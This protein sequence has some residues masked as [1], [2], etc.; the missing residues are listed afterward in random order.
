MKII[1]LRKDL[2]YV[3]V[4]DHDLK[5]FDVAIIT[6]YGTSYNSYL[7]KTPEGVVVF[8]GSKEKTEAEYLANLSSLCDFSEIKYL[9]VTH[10]EPDHS[11]AIK[12]LLE[13]NP[14][15]TVV[16][17][18]GALLNLDHIMRMPYNKK[19]VKEGDVLEFG[20]YHFRSVSGLMLHWPDVMFTYIEELKALVS[21]D[22]FGCHYAFDDILIS[23]LK[24]EE[25]YIDAFE[26]YYEKI[27]GPFPSFAKTAAGKVLALKPELILTGHGPVLDARVEERV[28]EYL[29]LGEK[30]FPSVKPGRV[31]LVY[32]SAYGFTKSMALRIEKALSDGGKDVHLYEIDAL[33]YA[34]VKENIIRDMYESELT[35]F[36]SPTVAG[37]AVCL[38]YD[39]MSALPSTIGNGR[40]ASAFG[41]Y[42]W[43]G[44]AVANLTARFTQLHF[45]VLPGFRANFSLDKDAENSFEAYIASLLA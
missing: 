21:C 16:A 41:D 29:T 11:G 7:L 4:V 17:S 13:K 24:D 19:S 15:I 35:L 28:S 42:G 43:S 45:K 9:F 6:K 12:A 27:M 10:T 38:F 8:E 14:D 23:K 37:D 18:A 31:T 3:G 2:Y 32:G 34:D 26:Y 36:G 39:I 20:G 33:N 22:A 40:K 5:V 1:E 30:F 25:G 44:E